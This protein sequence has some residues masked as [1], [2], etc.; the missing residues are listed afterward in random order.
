MKLLRMPVHS[1][2]EVSVAYIRYPG[3][4]QQWS[5]ARSKLTSVRTINARINTHTNA[6]TR[7][8]DVHFEEE[9]S[10][11][12]FPARTRAHVPPERKKK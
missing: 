12:A 9:G 5:A 7:P 6:R 2:P 8:Y 10:I 11:D 4:I 1:C 3:G